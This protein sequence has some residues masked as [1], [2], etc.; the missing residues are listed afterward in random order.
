[1]LP[2]IKK[3]CKYYNH[4]HELASFHIIS[5]IEHSLL[6]TSAYFPLST[7]HHYPLYLAF[8]LLLQTAHR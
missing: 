7:P 2:S 8:S 1:M 5:H 6:N 4:Q 3:P